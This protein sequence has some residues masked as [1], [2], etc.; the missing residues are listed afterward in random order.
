MRWHY[1]SQRFT[2]LATIAATM[3][4]AAIVLMPASLALAHAAFVS[5]DP[6]PNS[7]LKTVPTRVTIHFAQVLNPQGLSI[8]VYDNRGRPVSIGNAQISFSDPRSAS[9]AMK[10]D[11]SDIYRV[12]W[13]NISAEDGDPTLGAFVFGVSPTGTLDKVPANPYGSSIGS[14]SASASG[15]SSGLPIW[16]TAL[17]GVAGLLIGGAGSAYALTRRRLI[18]S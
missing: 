2:I 15:S 8:V 10:G 18:G 16:A 4:L 12:D 1:H 9:V 7:V 13:Q 17:V 6:A 14:G 11:G 5:S 3:A